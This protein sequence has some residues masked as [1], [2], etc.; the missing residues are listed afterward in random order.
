M[1]KVRFFTVRFGFSKLLAYIQICISIVGVDSILSVRFSVRF[2][3][4]NIEPFAS[5]AQFGVI[6]PHG[7]RCVRIVSLVVVVVANQWHRFSS[8]FAS[9]IG[10]V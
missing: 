9:D 6:R 2:A 1:Q 10:R 7:A 5:I 8:R 4:Q 3:S